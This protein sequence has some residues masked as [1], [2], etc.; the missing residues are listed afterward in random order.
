MTLPLQQPVAIFL[1]VLIMILLTPVLLRRLGIP[2]I[3]G[4][5]LAGIVVGPHGFG[6]LARDSSF[7]IFGQVGI[8]YLMF[9]AGV[10]IDML[11]LQRNWKSGVKFGL[12]SFLLPV[13]GGLL[14]SRYLMDCRRLTSAMIASMLGSHTL[15]S[16]PIVARF[17]L[18]ASRASVIA[19]CGTIVAVLLA[20]VLL[21]AVVGVQTSGNFRVADLLR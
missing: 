14:V 1:L 16:S 8:L 3:V 17:G 7:E 4:M 21:A 20:L 2:H 19:V 5:I 10:E 12:L 13:T 18:T 9:L 15:I 6:L 11:G